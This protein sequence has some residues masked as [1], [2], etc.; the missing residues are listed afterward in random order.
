MASLTNGAALK[1]PTAS[2]EPTCIPNILCIAL[3]GRV[4]SLAGS[5]NIFNGNARMD[6]ARLGLLPHHSWFGFSFEMPPAMTVVHEA[7]ET[8]HTLVIGTA[9]AVDVQWIHRG[10]ERL[11][12]H[13]LDQVAFFAS[14]NDVHTRVI[15]SGEAPSSS[16][17]LKIP[18]WHL[19]ALAGSD[20]AD[21][22]SDYPHLMP[23][24]DAVLRDCMVRLASTTGCGVA[25]DLG[26]EIA[27]RAL[28][29]RLVESLGG[30][31]PDW[32][33]DLGVFPLP[34]MNRIVQYIDAHL[35]HHI[36]LEQIAS[37]VGHS[38]SHC[39]RKFRH[40]EGLSLGRFVNRRR[41]AKAL[42]VLRRDSTPLSQVA[43]DLGFSSQSHFTRLFST[44]VGITPSK[45]R[46]TF[47]RPV[48]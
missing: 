41:L 14:D 3:W 46:K 31:A 36:S 18:R 12:R 44:L 21:M 48:G 45:Y 37:L 23:R 43:L 47:K 4:R 26:S 2:T 11:Y 24:E 39:A 29:L 5:V 19:L 13:G 1:P 28:I 40:T 17:L 32:H 33:E 30:H 42:V 34:A 25:N 38:P 7:R 22:P 10:C 6:E 35:H 8:N 16:Y 15:R 20:E 27:A 9:A